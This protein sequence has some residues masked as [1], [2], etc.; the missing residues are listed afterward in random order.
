[1]VMQQS[2]WITDRTIGFQGSDT[3][4]TNWEYYDT[5]PPQMCIKIPYYICVCIEMYIKIPYWHK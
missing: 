3:R 4:L 2:F 5:M 1:M